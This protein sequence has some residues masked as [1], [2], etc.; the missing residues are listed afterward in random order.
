LRV[1]AAIAVIGSNT[2]TKSAPQLHGQG[3]VLE[4]G[5][6]FT[7]ISAMSAMTAIFLE[8]RVSPFL[9]TLLPTAP[10]FF[11]LV[12]ALAE[13]YDYHSQIDIFART[14]AGDDHRFRAKRQTGHRIQSG[15]RAY[16]AFR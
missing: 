14:V 1:I 4:C 3:F 12:R 6:A 2:T 11:N 10:C 5:W 7:P 9:K 16:Q 15:R 13:T 8:P